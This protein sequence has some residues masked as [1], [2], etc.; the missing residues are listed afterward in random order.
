MFTEH[1]AMQA[2]MTRCHGERLTRPNNV[3]S[4]FRSIVD[5]YDTELGAITDRFRIIQTPDLIAAI[6]I[7]QD[8]LGLKMSP[9]ESF[10]R[11]GRARV[12]FDVDRSFSIPTAKTS[13]RP[14]LYLSHGLGGNGG[15][16]IAPTENISICTNGMIFG[17]IFQLSYARHIG[18]INVMQLVEEVL[19]QFEQQVE[20]SVQIITVASQ[21][22][23]AEVHENLLREVLESAGKRQAKALDDRLTE[24][25]KTHGDTVWALLQAVT[26]HATHDR[27]FTQK[28]GQ[29]V[30]AADVWSQRQ[31]SNIISGT[32]ELATI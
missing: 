8:K 7:V 2:A 15:I 13:V 25:I 19:E 3:S 14:G 26:E 22:P 18:V 10:Y 16:A 20:Y 9:R 27:R 28:D 23:S 29:Y 6:D 11:N 12:L 31:V 30:Q 24:N 1:P 32:P 17:A 21:T 5:E 4:R